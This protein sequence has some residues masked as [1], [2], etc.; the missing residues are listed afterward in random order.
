C[1]GLKTKGERLSPDDAEKTDFKP[2]VNMV[3]SLNPVH[4]IRQATKGDAVEVA[5][6]LTALGFPT[7]EAEVAARW[8]QW[9]AAGNFALVAANADGTLAGAVTLHEMRVL[10]RPRPVG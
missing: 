5:R 6:L 9:A 2:E 7:S 8:D 1:N 3:N 10:H 4:S